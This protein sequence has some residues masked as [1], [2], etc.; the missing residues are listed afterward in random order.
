MIRK[1]KILAVTMLMVFALGAVGAEGDLIQ[2][3]V[4][5]SE[6]LTAFKATIYMA[7][8]KGPKAE[9]EFEFAFVPPNKMRIEYLAPENLAGQL[10]ILNGNQLYTYLPLLHR[11]VRKKVKPG[12]EHPGT[13]MGFLYFF[14]SRDL[15]NF[16]E[17]YVPEEI[18]TETFAWE[19]GKQKKIYET[20]RITFV[21]E[22]GK[23]VVWCDAE[24]F[25]PV[26]VDI[27]QGNKLVMEVRVLEYEY[28]GTIL[29]QEFAIPG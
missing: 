2:K 22:E 16:L 23:Q 12:T 26:A 27:Y 7:N 5:V 25:V 29:P 17:K 18:Q 24:T 14:V 19:H 20:Y 9:I 4:T 28:N 1:G 15:S 10:V 13:E 3:I 8:Y 11:A 6:G 21:S